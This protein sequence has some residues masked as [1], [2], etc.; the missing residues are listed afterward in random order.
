M[1][2]HG[3]E[4]I[5]EKPLP[6]YRAT[7]RRLRHR[8]TGAD[9]YHVANDDRENLFAFAFKTL[10]RDST[11]VAHILEHSV[12]CGSRNYPLKDP[13]ILL[14]KGSLNTFLNAMTYPDK[15]IYPASSTVEQ[16]LF[17]IMRV[18]GDAVFFPLLQ[19]ELFRQEG[20]RIEITPDGRFDLTGIVYNEMKGNYANHDSVAARWSHRALLPDTPYGFDSGGDPA[21]IPDLTY[22]DFLG[23]HRTWYHPSNARIFLYGDIPTDRYLE[24]LDRRFLSHFG[25][26]D[27]APA[28]PDQP[29]WASPRDLVVTCPSDGPDGP[30]SVT[31]SWLLGPV[32]EPADLIAHELLSYILLGTSA[33]PLRRALIESGLGEDLSAPT[34]LETDLKEMVLGVG[35]RGTSP[36]RK[37]GIESLVL[38]S[39]ERIADEGIHADIVEAAFRTVEFRNREIKGGGP[40]GLRLMGRALRGWLHG[41]APEVTMCFE[42]PFETLRRE[43]KADAR[44]FENLIAG[45]LLQNPHRATVTVRPDPEQAE[46]E[47]AVVAARLAD[48]AAGMTEPERRRLEEEK[49]ALERLQSQPDPPEAIERIPF[50]SVN[51]LPREIETIPTET[52]RVNGVPLVCHDVFANGV[53]YLDL[54]FDISELPGELLPFVPLYVDVI[55]ELGLPGRSYDEVATEIGLRMGGFGS[56]CEAGLAVGETASA[57]R[58]VVFRIKVLESTAEE[59]LGLVLKLL[60]ESPFDNSDRLDD[61]V[62]EAKSGMSGAVLPSGHHFAAVRAARSFSDADRHEEQ[63]RGVTQLLFI[64]ERAGASVGSCGETLARIAEG[65]IRRETLTL[66]LTCAADAV[67]PMTRLLERF[68]DGLPRGLPRGVSSHVPDAAPAAEHAA[69]HSV[70]PEFESL[71]VP[72]DVAYVAAACRGARYGSPRAVHEQVLAHLLRTGFLWE[73]IRM[74]GGAYGASASARGLDGVFGF[75]SYRDPRI[76]ETLT[77]FRA[78]LER[79]A[80]S[81]VPDDELE[82]AVIGVTGHHIRPLSPGEKGIVALRR[83][84]YG[85]TDAMRQANRETLL[86]TTPDDVRRAAAGLLESMDDARVVVMAGARGIS[87][88]SGEVPDLATHQMH[89]PV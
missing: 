77:A 78:G 59:A 67:A 51:D 28:V 32:T 68:V 11:G 1:N 20:H 23:F 7:G 43:A 80:A 66:N 46:R 16:D 76:I 42:E 10:P 26:L 27:I 37:A 35:L 88:A 69:G 5:D 29:R 63:W 22:E 55:G 56:Y 48:L 74:K 34:G 36:D 38:D 60:L 73:A 84:L 19:P 52:R 13:F 65:V 25:K 79:F 12:L 62:K 31:M 6:E 39:L 44:F 17:N 24:L 87:E 2:R 49:A 41:A 21:A 33:G 53:I 57:G 45:S 75:W 83:H 14:V 4:L 30:T 72:S 3:F 86:A 8:V 64:H 58:S 50:L 47:R 9:V 85:V 54:V 18:Y 82:L 61:L 81:P 71:L 40:N 89:L 15:T 70:T